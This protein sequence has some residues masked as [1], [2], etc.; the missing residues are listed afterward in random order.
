MATNNSTEIKNG[1][2]SLEVFGSLSKNDLNE[3]WWELHP[4]AV[5][6]PTDE[7]KVYFNGLAYDGLNSA[8]L[9]NALSNYYTKQEVVDLIASISANGT[10]TAFGDG[11][12]VLYGAEERVVSVKIGDN[13]KF[14]EHTY[15]NA[16]GPKKIDV[17]TT[18]IQKKLTPGT[19]IFIDDNGNIS[20]T[21]DLS[22]Y[23]I[24]NG[25]LLGLLG[26]TGDP[27]KIYLVADENNEANNVFE[28]WIYY[29]RSNGSWSWEKIGNFRSEI[30]LAPYIKKENLKGTTINGTKTEVLNDKD[31]GTTI[32]T[33]AIIIQ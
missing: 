11:L 18:K 1:K 30:D 33:A 23:K 27:S 14:I 28:E 6:F 19:G 3:E 20:S 21:L 7:N 25:P 4:G 13:L 8:D 5:V 29:E 22:L 17:D 15:P 31:S 26:S 16:S 10:K 32:I 12:S 9:A 24:W 2:F